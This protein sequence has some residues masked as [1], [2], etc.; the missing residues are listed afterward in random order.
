MFFQG[1]RKCSVSLVAAIRTVGFAKKTRL[2]ARLRHHPTAGW[3]TSNQMGVGR[4]ADFFALVSGDGLNSPNSAPHAENRVFYSAP[5]RP[6]VPEREQNQN[7]EAAQSFTLTTDIGS[8]HAKLLTA[9]A[10]KLMPD[11]REK[12]TCPR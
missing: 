9:R 3:T 11:N 2:S 10:G 8:A 5:N 4:E 1:G 12:P 7:Y 6:A